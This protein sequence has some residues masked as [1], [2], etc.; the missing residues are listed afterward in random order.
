MISN[1]TRAALSFD[2]KITRI[3]SDQIAHHSV[4]TITIIISIALSGFSSIVY[5]L[6]Q[7]NN[8]LIHFEHERELKILLARNQCNHEYGLFSLA[9]FFAYRLNVFQE[10]RSWVAQN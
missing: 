5:L 10:K 6:Y 3:I 4:P 7:L 9:I 8:K 1:Q 2:F